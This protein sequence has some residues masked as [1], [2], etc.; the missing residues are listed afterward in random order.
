[1]SKSFEESEIEKAISLLESAES[2]EAGSFLERIRQQTEKFAEGMLL[3]NALCEETTE[4]GIILKVKNLRRAYTRKMLMFF[5]PSGL[6]DAEI[7][8]RFW[9]CTAIVSKDLGALRVED[10]S[11]DQ[12]YN[13]L[14][15]TMPIGNFD[16][17]LT[18]EGYAFFEGYVLKGAMGLSSHEIRILMNKVRNNE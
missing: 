17:P 9:A 1:M 11:I 15:N 7:Y 18:A 12:L 16:E 10:A 5:L 2:E 6:S 8:E 3:L 14:V 13:Q 4:P